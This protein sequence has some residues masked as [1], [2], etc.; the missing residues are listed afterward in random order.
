ML[1][2]AGFVAV[3]ADPLV[4]KL[5]VFEDWTAR[6]SMPPEERDG[7]E[8][9]LLAAPPRLAEFFRITAEDGRVVSLEATFGVIAALTPTE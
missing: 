4:R 5:Y 3:A 9:W 1:R 8:R 2:A 6:Q 7:L